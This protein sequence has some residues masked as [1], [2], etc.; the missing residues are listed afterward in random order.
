MQVCC[1]KAEPFTPTQRDLIRLP[2]VDGADV[3]PMYAPV[4]L[5]IG[6]VVSRIFLWMFDLAVS[7]LLQVNT[8]LLISLQGTHCV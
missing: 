2:A 6:V 4:L 7:Q 3:V 5:I 8:G 1:S